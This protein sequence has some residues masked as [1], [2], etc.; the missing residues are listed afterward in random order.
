MIAFNES[1]CT[2]LCC[3]SQGAEIC[4]LASAAAGASE[5]K[6]PVSEKTSDYCWVLV[7]AG[8]ILYTAMKHSQLS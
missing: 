6:P 2:Y 5:L 1:Y 7:P 8:A 4:E 3:C